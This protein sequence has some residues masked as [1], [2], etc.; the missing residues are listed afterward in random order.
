M[1]AK[2]DEL[3]GKMAYRRFWHRDR[4]TGQ[5]VV[6]VGFHELYQ[7]K[8]NCNETALKAETKALSDLTELLTD[9]GVGA[10]RHTGP[11]GARFVAVPVA[12][13]EKIEAIK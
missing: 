9:H 7:G 1:K 8:G 13:R 3:V 5:D 2:I 6:C 4:D 10:Y 11:T 12:D